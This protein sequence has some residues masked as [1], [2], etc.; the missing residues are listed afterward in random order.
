MPATKEERFSLP[1]VG[2]LFLN[3]KEITERPHRVRNAFDPKTCYETAT[4]C[5]LQVAH[6][7]V[8]G[9]VRSEPSVFRDPADNEF[10][11]KIRFV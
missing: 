5:Q 3:K 1:L 10:R 7:P 2:R 8:D 9:M 4:P 11:V 6:H